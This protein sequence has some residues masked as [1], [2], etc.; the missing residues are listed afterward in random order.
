MHF[1]VT[2]LQN[3]HVINAGNIKPFIRVCNLLRGS[4][5]MFRIVIFVLVY[6]L[7]FEQLAVKF[8]DLK[9]K[10][11]VNLFQIDLDDVNCG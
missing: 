6:V 10:T 1:V 8:P 3:Q 4:W 2:L 7:L 11:N 5:F 9:L